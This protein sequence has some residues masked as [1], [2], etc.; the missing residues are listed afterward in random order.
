MI[1][2]A[3]Q[4][5]EALQEQQANLENVL[6][7]Q[8]RRY[9]RIGTG[10][11]R[12]GDSWEY[13]V[14]IGQA[15]EFARS[16]IASVSEKMD[17][18]EEQIVN[19]EQEDTTSLIEEAR[20]YVGQVASYQESL[21][22][23]TEGFNRGL[24]KTSV[25][26]GHVQRFQ[27]LEN[28]PETD[29]ALKRGLELLR[30]QEE[31]EKSRQVEEV[32]E[33]N[34][35]I[36]TRT[37]NVVKVDPFT[38]MLPDDQAPILLRSKVS[39]ELFIA[40]AN[41]STNGLSNQDIERIR[42]AFG[43]KTKPGTLVSNLDITLHKYEPFSVEEKYIRRRTDSGI[44]YLNAQVS[45]AET[46]TQPEESMKQPSADVDSSEQ[47]QIDDFEK[48]AV[49]EN[50]ALIAALMQN[51]VGTIIQLDQN[52]NMVFELTDEIEELFEILP[53]GVR[54]KNGNGKPHA[55]PT[56]DEIKQ[57]R[58]DAVLWLKP[59]YELYKNSEYQH[60]NEHVDTLITVMYVLDES[61]MGNHLIPFLLAEPEEKIETKKYQEPKLKII[62]RAPTEMLKNIQ[63]WQAARPQEP[64]ESV[65]EVVFAQNLQMLEEESVL[66]AELSK[67]PEVLVQNNYEPIPPR[68]KENPIEKRD[69]EVKKKLQAD[70][71]DVV[72]KLHTED[73]TVVQ[74]SAA[75][76]LHV[77][78][79]GRIVKAL[80]LKP[81]GKKAGKLLYDRI[82]ATMVE[83]AREYDV[84]KLPLRPDEIE[85]LKH[86]AIALYKE[87]EDQEKLKV[88]VENKN[89][90]DSH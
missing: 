47:V 36:I 25:Y 39:R 17:T 40:L 28:R 16:S 9:E 29:E 46:D 85:A 78:S 70:L 37:L 34:E 90:N 71:E 41:A 48:L 6:V 27:Q 74:I 45:F 54:I 4:T 79:V 51:R 8:K 24:V 87:W 57:R 73:S 59:I 86:L 77:K 61:V 60:P 7:S 38:I 30:E 69:P 13:D 42:E 82:G 67:E 44:Y 11:H 12:E 76:G 65:V 26:E 75:I 10:K 55:L 2:E 56:T 33:R 53:V 3:P 19:F 72:A 58:R 1:K 62:W 22:S 66:L 68:I 43:S 31:K 5:F 89:G 15:R 81:S 20:S 23:L 21:Q 64:E 88:K 84:K 63:S 35:A 18:I 83:Y 49:R 14:K 32:I 50:V 80:K 52:A